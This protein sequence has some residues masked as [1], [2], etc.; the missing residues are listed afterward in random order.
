MIQQECIL[1]LT[2]YSIYLLH[3]NCLL[4]YLKKNFNGKQVMA[5]MWKLVKLVS[6]GNCSGKYIDTTCSFRRTSLINTWVLPH[7]E[8]RT[9]STSPY[10]Y[11]LSESQQLKS[12]NNNDLIILYTKKIFSQKKLGYIAKEVILIPIIP[13]TNRYRYIFERVMLQPSM[14]SLVSVSKLEHNLLSET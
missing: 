2:I 8:R 1:I 4:V 9:L 11:R 14:L 5:A 12:W 10:L 3:G 6:P 13:H 7:K